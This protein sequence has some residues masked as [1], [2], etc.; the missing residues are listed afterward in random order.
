MSGTECIVYENITK[1]SKFLGESLSVLGLFFSVAGVLKKNN[2]SVLHCSYCSLGIGADNFGICRENDRLAEAFCQALCYGSQRHL[3]LGLSLRLAE[4]GAKDDLAAV[5]DQFLDS[6]Q[7]RYD[8][9][10][11]SDDAGLQRNVEVASAQD[12]FALY[13]DIINGFLIQSHNIIPPLIE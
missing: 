5:S 10:V 11:V 12:I 7:S 1:R 6:G 13:V 9:V 2:I 3:G 8:T 4:V